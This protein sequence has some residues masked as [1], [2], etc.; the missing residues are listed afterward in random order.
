[1]VLPR[2]NLPQLCVPL[3]LLASCSCLALGCSARREARTKTTL[4]GRDAAQSL[5]DAPPDTS[6]WGTAAGLRYLEFVRGG[7][8]PES[9][10]PLLVVFHGME[11]S[12]TVDYLQGLDVDDA[13]QVR[14]I[15]PQAPIPVGDSGFSWFDARLLDDRSDADKARGISETLERVVR[16]L[17]VIRRQ[18]PTRGRV[19][20]AG[21]S[22]GGMLTYALASRHPELVEF[23]LPVSGYLP[24]PL[25][26]SRAE[27]WR[28]KLRALH[29]TADDIVPHLAAEQ[30]VA[31]LQR[32]GY[33]TELTLFEGIDHHIS[34]DMSAAAHSALSAALAPLQPEPR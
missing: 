1:M 12:P 10:L 25:W 26:P 32:I 29:G 9:A 20:V 22:Q 33:E 15:R 18:R 8:A 11:G 23:A 6:G 7:A 14:V 27:G 19:V 13:T 16:M 21:F 5:P 4:P 31:S 2:R 28:P 3:L 24:K 34:P 30:L 17:T